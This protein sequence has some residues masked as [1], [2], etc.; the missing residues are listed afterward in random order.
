M[1]THNHTKQERNKGG[2]KGLSTCGDMSNQILNKKK[3]QNSEKFK[4]K[5]F[6]FTKIQIQKRKYQ[7]TKKIPTHVNSHLVFPNCTTTPLSV[8]F[9]PISLTSR[10][11]RPSRRI[12]LHNAVHKKSRVKVDIIYVRKRPSYSVTFLS[13]A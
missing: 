1:R 10:E 11:V 2:T 8:T 9:I 4:F 7:D 5:K 6:K 13:M 12:P 3:N